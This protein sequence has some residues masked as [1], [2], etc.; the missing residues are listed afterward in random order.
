MCLAV[1]LY[2]HVNSTRVHCL[3]VLALW[4][5]LCTRSRSPRLFSGDATL[6]LTCYAE[7]YWQKHPDLHDIPIYYMGQLAVKCLSVYAAQIH[8]MNAVVQ[9]QWK[10]GRN[11][12]KFQHI[13]KI[14]VSKRSRYTFAVVV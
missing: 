9:E 4:M 14:K 3:S 12:F 11:P 1:V 6:L 13:S 5:R 8:S 2:E 7:D 10:L